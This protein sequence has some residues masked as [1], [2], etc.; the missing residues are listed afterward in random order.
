MIV[1]LGQ[2]HGW[3]LHGHYR[4][5]EVLPIVAGVP[6]GEIDAVALIQTHDGPAWF[7]WRWDDADAIPIDLPGAVPGGAALI[8]ER[9]EP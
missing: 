4:A 1:Q 5:L 8:V 9:V 3:V 7:I 6:R 2:R